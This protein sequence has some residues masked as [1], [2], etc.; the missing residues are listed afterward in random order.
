MRKPLAN[1]RIRAS[2]VRVIDEK[3]EQLGIFSLKEALQKAKERNLDLVQ[4]TEKVNP[5]VCK[6]ID[7]GKYVYS[8]EKKERQAKK[9]SGGD[10]KEIRLGFNI[11]P[12][13]LETKAKLA[14]KF[15]KRGDKVRI[16]MVLR[17]RE[18]ALSDF[19]KN[20]I[21]QFLQAL[22]QKLPLQAE[23]DLKRIGGRLIMIV[24][25]K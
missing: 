3:G 20:K 4:I 7:L 8:L 19:A 14:E 11:S 17:G 13:D 9:S 23:Q 18:R 6:I 25:K 12:H 21:D 5:P 2:E 16:V 24:M 22:E 15:L 1:N 10:L